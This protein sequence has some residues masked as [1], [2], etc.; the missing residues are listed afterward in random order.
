MSFT[1]FMFLLSILLALCEVVERPTVFVFAEKIT[2]LDI[3][4]MYLM[5]FDMLYHKLVK[6]KRKLDVDLCKSS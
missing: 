2:F 1:S 4:D 6:T 3:S 5:I